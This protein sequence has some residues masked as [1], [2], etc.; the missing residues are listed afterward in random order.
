MLVLSTVST[1]VIGALGQTVGHEPGAVACS[2]HATAPAAPRVAAS[3]AARNPLIA[4]GS[5]WRTRRAGARTASSA[6]RS[7]GPR[8]SPR[9]PTRTRRA[10][11][12]T[13]RRAR[14]RLRVA[15]YDDPLERARP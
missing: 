13:P 6:A 15:H 1:T 3:H 4:P 8:R 11:A 9:G 14:R 12:G 7:S 10:A 2:T 5:P